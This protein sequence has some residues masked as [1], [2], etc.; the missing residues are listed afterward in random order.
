MPATCYTHFLSSSVTLDDS[1]SKYIKLIN[2]I[3]CTYDISY[4]YFYLIYDITWWYQIHAY[5]HVYTVHSIKINS[6]IEHITYIYTYSYTCTLSLQF[7]LLL[8]VRIQSE[9]K[10]SKRTQRGNHL[11]IALRYLQTYVTFSP[12]FFSLLFTLASHRKQ[13]VLCW[14]S[15]IVFDL[16]LIMFIW[17]FHDND[18]SI[19]FICLF[20][21]CVCICCDSMYG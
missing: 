17:I 13:V 2:C 8:C 4:L 11:F 21:F 5:H 7:P 16:I 6:V 20:F 3:Y 1:H 15:W 10:V 18:S 9:K 12:C 14:N 19:S